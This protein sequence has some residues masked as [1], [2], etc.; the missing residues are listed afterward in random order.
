[1]VMTWTALKSRQVPTSICPSGAYK[2]L[3]GPERTLMVCTSERC[4]S[5]HN[6]TDRKGGV[7][8][9][10]K[11]GRV[12]VRLGVMAMVDVEVGVEVNGSGVCDGVD[13]GED[14]ISVVRVTVGV[15]S[16]GG[17]CRGIR[18]N[19]NRLNTMRTGIPN[20]SNQGGSERS[21]F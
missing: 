10:V 19:A 13:V 6:S 14:A 20:R 5:T 17:L 12:G 7:A 4:T 16:G 15:S 18:N 2:I 1:M 9:G 8:D 11:V 21:A 3:L